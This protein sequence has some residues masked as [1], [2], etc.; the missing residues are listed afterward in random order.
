MS[1]DAGPITGEYGSC[2]AWPERRV[3]L[4]QSRPDAV[5]VLGYSGARTPVPGV[6]GNYFVILARTPHQSGQ[7]YRGKAQLRISLLDWQKFL[8]FGLS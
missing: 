2:V 5:R 4:W 7:P 3:S 8:A 1:L 6:D